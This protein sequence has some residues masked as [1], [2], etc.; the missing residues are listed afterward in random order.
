V[1]GRVEVHTEFWWGNRERDHLEDLG[2]GGRI[3][4]RGIFRNWYVRAWTRSM[5]LSIGTGGGG[6][7]CECGNELCGSIKC[8]ELFV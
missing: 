8:G 7:T 1:W 2:I 6:G 4:L 3:I 5:W